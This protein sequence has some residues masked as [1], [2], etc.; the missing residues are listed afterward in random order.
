MATPLFASCFAG[1]IVYE[2]F[3]H[4]LRAT[5]LAHFMAFNLIYFVLG[6]KY[7]VRNI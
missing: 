6:E 2:F 7:S 3:N 5:C 1:K 4:I